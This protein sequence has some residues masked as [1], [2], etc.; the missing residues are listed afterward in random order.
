MQGAREGRALL[1]AW[2]RSSLR[3][4]VSE[5]G[6]LHEADAPSRAFSV[7]GVSLSDGG[8]RSRLDAQ[9][10]RTRAGALESAPCR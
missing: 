2:L 7:S 9:N 3:R 1:N 10:H 4:G 5:R 8:V 6:R